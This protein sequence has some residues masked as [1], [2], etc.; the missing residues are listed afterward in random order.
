[1]RV[2]EFESEEAIASLAALILTEELK[3]NPSLLL[4]AAT[5]NSPVSLYK[6]LALEY[7]HSN[8]LFDNMRVIA[9]DEWVGLDTPRGSCDAYL[10]EYLVEPLGISEERFLRFNAKAQNLDEECARLQVYL[11]N[12]GPIDL[13]VL[14]FGKNG[15][16]GFNEPAARLQAHCH[17]ANLAPK[18]RRHA[19]LKGAKTLPAQGLTLGMQDILSSNRI[20]LIISGGGKEKAKNAF[21]TKKVQPQLPASFLWRHANVDCLVLK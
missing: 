3:K 19:M 13:C 5:G 12:E 16:L 9:L 14:G 17:V 21:F 8:G 11:N 1:M 15:H 10:R 7:G 6:K 20:L 4:C 18:S 2:I